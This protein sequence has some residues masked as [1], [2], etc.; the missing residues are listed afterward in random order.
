M[1]VL[2][3]DYKMTASNTRWERLC[4]QRLCLQQLAKNFNI[5]CLVKKNQILKKH[6]YQ[7]TILLGSSRRDMYLLPMG[8][9]LV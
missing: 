8:Q 1:Y 5:N 2:Y 4:L 7:E 3:N 6:F 9:M